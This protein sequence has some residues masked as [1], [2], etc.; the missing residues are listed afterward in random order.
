MKKTQ[1]IMQFDKGLHRLTD[2]MYMFLFLNIIPGIA[3]FRQISTNG[4][5]LLLGLHPEQIDR[6]F[7]KLEAA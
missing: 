3:G 4:L 1:K 7:E 2:Y 6:S 5:T